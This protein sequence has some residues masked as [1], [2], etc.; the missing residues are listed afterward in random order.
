[1][2]AEC[3]NHA[4]G[5]EDSEDQKFYCDACWDLQLGA[6]LGASA[7]YAVVRRSLL[8]IE[9]I[10]QQV[11]SSAQLTVLAR[12]NLKNTHEHIVCHILMCGFINLYSLSLSLALSPTHTYATDVCRA[13]DEDKLTETQGRQRVGDELPGKPRFFLQIMAPTRELA[14]QI[15]LEARKLTNGSCIVPVVRPMPHRCPCSNLFIPH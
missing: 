4:V 6:E 7:A 2:C 8:H 15:H 10:Q 12:S 14:L 13:S 11:L 1:M 9:I 3:G 5:R